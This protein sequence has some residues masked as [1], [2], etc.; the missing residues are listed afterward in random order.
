MW[1]GRGCLGGGGKRERV[2][3]VRSGGEREGSRRRGEGIAGFRV[4]AAGVTPTY[5]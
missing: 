2:N 5:N 3:K 1:K 4:L